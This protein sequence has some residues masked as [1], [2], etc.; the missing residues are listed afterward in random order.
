MI[1]FNIFLFYPQFFIFFAWLTFGRMAVNPFGDDETDINLDILL[2]SH[3]EV[4]DLAPCCLLAN[5][6][7][8]E[9]LISSYFITGLQQTHKNLWTKVGRLFPGFGEPIQL[10]LLI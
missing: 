8:S 2:E 10:W 7:P 1:F 5:E 3:I 4:Y 9:M 6:A